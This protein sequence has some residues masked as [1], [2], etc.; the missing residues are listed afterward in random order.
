MP[1]A[2]TLSLKMNQFKRA[3]P[4]MEILKND[5]LRERHWKLLI[6]KTGHCFEMHSTDSF[7]LENIFAMELHK[8]QVINEILNAQ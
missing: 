4:L 5:A 6:G 3:V 7:V 8:H 2:Q 1:I